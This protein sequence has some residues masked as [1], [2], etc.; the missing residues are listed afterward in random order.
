MTVTAGQ[1]RKLEEQV[2][3]KGR[4]SGGSFVLCMVVP[5]ALLSLRVPIMRFLNLGGSQSFWRHLWLNYHA[6]HG[7]SIWLVSEDGVQE[8]KGTRYVLSCLYSLE[9]TNQMTQ[10]DLAWFDS[11]GFPGLGETVGKG[12][13]A[14]ALCCWHSISP[15]SLAV[16]HPWHAARRNS[17]RY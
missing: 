12:G 3:K 8:E 7:E 16:H 2:E 9:P 1:G 11:H 10:L 6:Q 17:C 15:S 4:N 14:L 13:Q 5:C